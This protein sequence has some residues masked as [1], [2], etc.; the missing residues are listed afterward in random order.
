MR[1]LVAAVIGGLAGAVAALAVSAA[2]NAPMDTPVAPD[3]SVA[4]SVARLAAR[5]DRLEREAAL[6]P[7]SAPPAGLV[8]VP[9]PGGEPQEFN[10]RGRHDAETPAP[11]VAETPL[12]LTKVA[13]ADLALEADERHARDYDIAGAAKRYREL[14]ARGGSPSERRHWSIRLGD[15]YLRLHR[16]D[17]AMA[18]YRDCVDASTEDHAERVACMIALARDARNRSPADARRWIDRALELSEGRS[19]RAVHEVAV[20]LARDA[21]Q[22]DVEA[23]ELGWL[24]EH[25]PDEANA[26]AGWNERIVQLRGEKR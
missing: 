3:D 9:T 2:M 19:N 18:A 16:D 11:P 5:V 21:N 8:P 20:F 26:G 1:P 24:V 13:S 23:R 12:D 25:F 6:R 7:R 15:C 14:L 17:E 10:G 4:R 22:A